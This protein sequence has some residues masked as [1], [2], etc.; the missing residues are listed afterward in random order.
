MISIKSLYKN[1]TFL[2]HNLTLF[3]GALATGFFNYLYYPVLGRLLTTKQFGE[4]QTLLSLYTQVSIVLGVVGVS[5]V[6]FFADAKNRE[7]ASRV[8]FSTERASLMFMTAVVGLCVLLSGVA[9]KYLYFD[10]RSPFVVAL[11]ALLVGTVLAVRTAYLQ[12]QKLFFEVSITS[13]LFA[14]SSLIMSVVFV[15]LG[16]GTLGAMYGLVAGQT[17]SAAYA[18]RRSRQ[19]G[20]SNSLF[21]NPTMFPDKSTFKLFTKFSL[22]SFIVL[23]SVSFVLSVDVILVKH[24]F[25]AEQAGLYAGIAVISRIVFFVTSSA[26]GVMLPSV[27]VSQ[28]L[29]HNSRILFKS[30]ML[31]AVVGGLATAVFSLLP[32]L[33]IKLLLG[34]KYV[35]LSSTLPKLSLAVFV[36]SLANLM[37]RYYLAL[38]SYT[39]GFIAVV[40]VMVTAQS[41][42][43]THSTIDDV[44]RGILYGGIVMVA[45]LSAMTV[46][47]YFKLT[48]VEV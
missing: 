13:V 1:N 18:I 47:P 35:A 34:S 22:L 32:E 36:V 15:K 17:V 5:S 2:K 21:E 44:V 42:V 7:R 26:A 41:I 24:Y 33:S 14:V 27:N 43:Q 11:L 46:K 38:K 23:L 29:E 45:L 12:A 31:V 16:F 40:G 37:F 6:V 28:T 39:I 20:W 30:L 4:T 48:K 9:S 25:S 8:L 3:A 10:S 19:S